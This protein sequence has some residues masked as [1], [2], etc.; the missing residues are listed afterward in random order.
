MANRVRVSYGPR[1]LRRS[2]AILASRFRRI[3]PLC[4]AFARFRANCHPVRIRPTLRAACRTGVRNAGD[5]ECSG[6]K[7]VAYICFATAAR[8][9]IRFGLRPTRLSPRN[10]KSGQLMYYE[11]RTRQ[12]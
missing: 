1:R 2:C 8:G 4:P 3:S 9:E 10:P 7:A 12:I 11:Y 6:M 5:P